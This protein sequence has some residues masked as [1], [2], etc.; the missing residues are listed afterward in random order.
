MNIV[1]YNDV[2]KIEQNAFYTRLLLFQSGDE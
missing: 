2:Y 1:L